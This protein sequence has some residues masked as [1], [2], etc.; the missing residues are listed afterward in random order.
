MFQLSKDQ[1]QFWIDRGGSY[2]VIVVVNQDRELYSTPG[3]GGFGP[4]VD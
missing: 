3:G 4:S 2:T 1:R